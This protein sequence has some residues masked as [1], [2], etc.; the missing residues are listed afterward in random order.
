[1]IVNAPDRP[2]CQLTPLARCTMN[3]TT[4]EHRYKVHVLTFTRLDFYRTVM[5]VRTRRSRARPAGR[6]EPPRSV[7]WLEDSR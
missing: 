6:A 5:Y 3:V 2:L 1:M 7:G 4:P